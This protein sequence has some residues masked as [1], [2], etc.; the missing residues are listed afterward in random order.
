MIDDQEQ[1][2]KLVQ[3]KGAHLP[4]KVEIVRS[5][6]WPIRLSLWWTPT[7]FLTYEG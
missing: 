4:I 3:L 7:S 1:V 6:N 2:D 5:R